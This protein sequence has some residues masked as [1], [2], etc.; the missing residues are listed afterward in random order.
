[1]N[2]QQPI[3]TVF[4][5]S[6]D[7]DSDSTQLNEPAKKLVLATSAVRLQL[8]GKEIRLIM[9]FANVYGWRGVCKRM[10]A[11][12]NCIFT[13]LK[14]TKEAIF[15]LIEKPLG[16][17]SRHVLRKSSMLQNM[18][19]ADFTNLCSN[20]VDIRS[21]G[22]YF[23][24]WQLA[25]Y[26][27]ELVQMRTSEVNNFYFNI[28][29]FTRFVSEIYPVK[30]IMPRQVMDIVLIALMYN[31]INVLYRFVYADIPASCYSK[32][33]RFIKMHFV[34][35]KYEAEVMICGQLSSNRLRFILESTEQ[36][37]GIH[38]RNPV[39]MVWRV[40]DIIVI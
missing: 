18:Q 24:M 16:E 8:D 27:T 32:L 20:T 21:A 6:D 7:E 28:K 23:F 10:E 37:E 3:F 9:Q 13:T 19:V 22:L 26:H 31:D 40:T 25:K 5:S 34:S 30:E 11:E 36:Q 4:D 14:P 12:L 2:Q 35:E 15:C 38:S 29:G 17:V 1:M 33:L 39:A